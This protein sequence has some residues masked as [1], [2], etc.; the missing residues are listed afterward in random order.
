MA[1]KKFIQFYI[2]FIAA[3]LML[4]M[5]I[6]LVGVSSRAGATPSQSTP[7][8]V[9]LVTTL[10]DEL[11]SD[12]DCSL[13]EAI[14][15][16]NE[17][18]AVDACPAGDSIITDTITFDVAG[19]ITVTSQLSVTAGGP[20]EIDGGNVITTSGGGTTRVWWVDPGSD[21]T[22]QDLVVA[23]G[24]LYND[25]GAGL[26]NN[27]ARL[28]VINTT[29]SNNLL[30]E[31][32]EYIYGAG[33][34]NMGGTVVVIN[35][36][37]SNNRGEGTE[38]YSCG[39]GISNLGGR[40]EVISS[41][42]TGNSARGGGGG[43]HNDDGTLTVTN[44]TFSGNSA[45]GGGGVFNGGSAF[46]TNSYFYGN[47]NTDGAGGGIEN[48]NYMTINNS[49][50]I[51]NNANYGGG[52][53][54]WDHLNIYSSTF[55]DNS[56]TWMGGGIHND[57]TMT[58][59]SSTIC[60]N[61]VEGDEYARGGGICNYGLGELTIINSTISG[62]SAKHGGGI[63]VGSPT[64]IINSTISGNSA[65]IL[66]GGA[67]DGASYMLTNSIIANNLSGG[68]CGSN[69]WFYDLGHNLDSDGT[70]GLDPAMGSLS[71][72]DPMLGPLRDNGGPTWTHALLPG[73]PA[74]DAGDDAQ[75]PPTDQRGVIRP[76][77]GNGD[78]EAVC[79]M[80]S[81]EFVPIS[82]YLPVVIKSVSAPLAPAS[83]SSPP[84]GG[85]LVGLVVVGVVSRWKRRE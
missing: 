79:D 29:F 72:T 77:D 8:G 48:V 50:F 44:T 6:F 75:C 45:L 20:L 46:I 35:S 49:T 23:D 56:T 78:G 41:T 9:M 47:G 7:E 26:Y 15:A 16:A 80:G 24:Y 83:T 28:T 67:I 69:L 42:L 59:E 51:G 53:S 17:N 19:T 27:A 11:N 31:Y 68:D 63:S 64:T 38:Y 61:H 4:G 12:G 54:N 74:T 32:G 10:E 73:S 34:S 85:V 58:I 43:I 33:I 36:T 3:C 13:R 5:L 40:L 37:F 25:N 14:T 70:C 81:Y 52:V 84:E 18:T 65:E 71:N 39:G 2:P 62:N 66:G 76:I 55:T 60:N 22:L 21:L 82:A 1:M 57:G 30:I